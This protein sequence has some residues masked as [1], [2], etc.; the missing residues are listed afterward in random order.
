MKRQLSAISKDS[1]QLSV[2][3]VFK[4]KTDNF[5]LIT[6]FNFPRQ[7]QERFY[8]M[9]VVLK[10]ACCIIIICALSLGFFSP[11]LCGEVTSGKLKWLFE[12]RGV[13]KNYSFNRPQ[14]MFLDRSQKKVYIA[15]TDNRKVAVFPFSGEPFSSDPHDPGR[16]LTDAGIFQTDRPLPS[17]LCIAT[18]SK[19]RV[20]ISFRD[21]LSL[22]VFDPKGKFLYS[23]PSPDFLKEHEFAAGK[24]ALS[25][26]G[27]LYV[28]NRKTQ[29]IWAFEQKD[30]SDNGHAKT[31]DSLA[32][33][34]TGHAKTQGS[35][36]VPVPAFSFRFGGRGSGRGEFQFITDIFFHD[37][38]LYLTDAQGI[39]VQVFT[40]LGKYLYSFGKHGQGAE[41]FSFPQSVSV[42]RSQRMWVAD[43]FRHRVR[44][45]NQ[46]GSFLFGIGSYGTQAGKLCFPVDLDFDDYGRIYILEKS[47]GRFQVFQVETR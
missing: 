18:D 20:Y 14:G 5:K 23:V 10:I 36:A 37:D 21:K 3:T 8:P 19:E 45:Y 47:G 13:R 31:Q 25:P 30:G 11:A 4:L 33:S 39:P 1:Y 26:A 46:E 44:V 40:S 27:K 9:R 42:D 6:S 29:E 34:A 43:A 2:K 41:D 12:I 22:E 24:F 38:K 32:V 35:V 16:M 15:D 7:L 17:P 28:I